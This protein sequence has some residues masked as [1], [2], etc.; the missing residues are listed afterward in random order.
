MTFSSTCPARE[1]RGFVA[2]CV[3]PAREGCAPSRSLRAFGAWG[4]LARTAYAQRAR[5]MSRRVRARRA[6]CCA[7]GSFGLSQAPSDRHSVNWEDFRDASVSI[8]LYCALS[9]YAK[10]VEEDSGGEPVFEKAGGCCEPAA[11]DPS[12][13]P[14][15]SA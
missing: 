14:S 9:S 11:D 8:G 6:L 13:P 10:C 1:R 5:P 4:A 15:S 7:P 2:R 3:R 12:A